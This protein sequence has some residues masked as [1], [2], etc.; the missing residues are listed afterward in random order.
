MDYSF[1]ALQI[2]PFQCIQRVPYIVLQWSNGRSNPSD[3]KAYERPRDTGDSDP[4]QGKIQNYLAFFTHPD[5]RGF[6][7][8]IRV[9]TRE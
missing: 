5:V 3:L 6:E 9:Y 7:G 1:I 8:H 2:L 4:H